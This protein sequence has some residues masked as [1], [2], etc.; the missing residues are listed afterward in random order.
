MD[1]AIDELTHYVEFDYLVVNDQF[2]IALRD[3]QAIVRSQRLTHRIQ[4]QKQENL[5]KS[6]LA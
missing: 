3:L 4:A 2:E 6:L 1:Q 5:L